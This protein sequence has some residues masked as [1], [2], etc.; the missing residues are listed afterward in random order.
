MASN[1]SKAASFSRF[2]SSLERLEVLGGDSKDFCALL[3]QRLPGVMIVGRSALSGSSFSNLSSSSC[4]TCVKSLVAASFEAAAPWVSWGCSEPSFGA[5]DPEGS[6]CGLETESS[7]ISSTTSL[8][9]ALASFC[10][11]RFFFTFF[12]IPASASFLSSWKSSKAHIAL[13]ITASSQRISINCGRRYSSSRR[14]SSISLRFSSSI[15]S[16]IAL[17]WPRT[18]ATRSAGR[19]GGAKVPEDGLSAPPS[20]ERRSLGIWYFRNSSKRSC[21]SLISFVRLSSAK[22]RSF[23]SCGLIWTTATPKRVL[24]S[25]IARNAFANACCDGER[26]AIASLNSFGVGMTDSSSGM[27][28]S[29]LFCTMAA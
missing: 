24:S 18:A 15:M 4:G 28:S 17:T 2:W 27:V 10:F 7:V 1:K 16:N 8:A 26:E 14:R 20:K 23:S 29:S 6:S 5:C 11:A 22:F 25:C 12:S 9:L 21:V 13:S 19:A 3:L